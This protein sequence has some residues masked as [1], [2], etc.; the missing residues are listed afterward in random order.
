[1]AS[2]LWEVYT[3]PTATEETNPERELMNGKKDRG[4]KK[5]QHAN[6][7]GGKVERQRN[8]FNL[9]LAV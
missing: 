9:H 8:T 1:M 5:D 3:P 4:L 2:A 6:E 7:E